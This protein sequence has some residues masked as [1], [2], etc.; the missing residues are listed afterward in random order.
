MSDHKNVFSLRVIPVLALFLIVSGCAVYSPHNKSYVSDSIEERTGHN[1]KMKAESLEFTL[2]E[3]VSLSD[4]MTED[5]AVAIALW[6]NAQYQTDLVQLGFARADLIEA[7]L[8]RNPIFS[9]LFPLG[10]KQLE[11]TLNLPLDFFWQRPNR[12]ASAK[13]NAEITADNLIQHG[14]NLIRDVR[15][16]YAGLILARERAGIFREDAVLQT[17]MAAISA[18]RLKAG[19]ISGLEET[20]F[21]LQAARTQEDAVRSARDAELAENRLAALLGIGFEDSSVE[22]S[23]S[24]LSYDLKLGISDLLEAAFVGRPDLRAAEIAIESAGQKVGWERAKIINFT[25]VLDVNGEGKEGFEMGPGGQFELPV[26]NRNKGKIARAQA[27]LEQASKQYLAVKHRIT[28][29]VREAQVHYLAADKALKIVQ[30]E[31]YPTAKTAEENAEVAYQIGDI[32]YL[33][34]L[35]FKRQFLDASLQQAE[36]KA[37]MR[38]AD[39]NLKHSLGFKLEN[40]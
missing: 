13:L 6:N 30:T 34:L 9:L 11:S 1:L 23:V 3:D 10:P 22:L 37:S 20:A 14:L 39:I 36:I 17:E 40:E 18:A 27:E 29:E 31:V 19:D 33:E 12:V 4:G 28:S 5:E 38:Q 7:G 21:R 2:P 15:G 26:F 25:A 35:N 32:S 8:L 16:A 24:P